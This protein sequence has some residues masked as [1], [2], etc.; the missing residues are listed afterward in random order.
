MLMKGCN[1]GEL[2]PLF[3]QATQNFLQHILLVILY[4]FNLY[5]QTEKMCYAIGFTKDMVSS[6]LTKKEAIRCNG[7]IYSEEHKRKFEI[8]NDIFMVE[9]N[10]TD[11]RKVQG[12]MEKLREGL[13][14]TEEPRKKIKDSGYKKSSAHLR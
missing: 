10:P 14:K 11:R 8:M 13:R 6:L 9:K 7:K 5:L 12:T 1:G 4:Y 3:H 2:P